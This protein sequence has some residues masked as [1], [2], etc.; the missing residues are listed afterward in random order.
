VPEQACG[1]VRQAYGD[2]AEIY[3]CE[4]CRT[5]YLPSSEEP[6]GKN[7]AGLGKQSVFGLTLTAR[8]GEEKPK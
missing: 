3:R 1:D 5:L 2:Q 4:H 6:R 8:P 7:V